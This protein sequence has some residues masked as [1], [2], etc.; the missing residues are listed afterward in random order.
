MLSSLEQVQGRGCVSYPFAPFGS[1]EMTVLRP[2]LWPQVT[3]PVAVLACGFSCSLSCVPLLTLLTHC[4][5][6]DRLHFW[7]CS[8][9]TCPHLSPHLVP[10]LSSEHCR[11]VVSVS[12]GLPEQLARG[13]GG[14]G[15]EG[16][17]GSC[18]A[19]LLDIQIQE[20]R[21][22]RL[23]PDSGPSV[24]CAWGGYLT[25]PCFSVSPL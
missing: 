15:L 4:H 7:D 20:P 2:G 9:C 23:T 19:E 10:S 3:W 6:R 22:L 24:P 11:L 21:R 25:Y 1:P 18:L 16:G 17:R 13:A 14:E 8:W 5:V 12:S